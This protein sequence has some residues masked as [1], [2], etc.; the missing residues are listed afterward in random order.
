MIIRLTDRVF[1]IKAPSTIRIPPIV[2]IYP[3]NR[4]VFRHTSGLASVHGVRMPVK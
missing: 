4:W 2:H 3:E 1:G